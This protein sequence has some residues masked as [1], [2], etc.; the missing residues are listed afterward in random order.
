L[1]AESGPFLSRGLAAIFFVTSVVF[2]WRSFY[3]MRIQGSTPPA[4]GATAGRV[5]VAARGK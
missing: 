4:A 2:V 1:T 3:A 5:A